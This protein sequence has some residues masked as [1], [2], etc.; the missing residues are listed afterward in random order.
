MDKYET[1]IYNFLIQKDNFEAMLKVYSHFSFV[2]EG[3]LNSFW[4]KVANALTEKLKDKPRWKIKNPENKERSDA[5]LLIYKDE[6]KLNENHPFVGIGWE[7]LFTNTYYGVWSHR[8]SKN[9]DNAALKNGLDSYKKDLK[10]RDD[11][12]WW[13]LWT[14]GPHNFAVNEDLIDI[15]PDKADAIA[16]EYVRLLCVIVGKCEEI[17]DEVLETSQ[18]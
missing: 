11:P 14:N 13:F 4:N 3:L 8:D 12:N 15:L 16:D 6:W 2:K 5:K 7:H 18:A 1:E 9:I 17:I 10:F